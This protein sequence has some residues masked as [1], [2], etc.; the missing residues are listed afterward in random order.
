MDTSFS[1]AVQ[2]MPPPVAVVIRSFQEFASGVPADPDLIVELLK[3][4]RHQYII[5]QEKTGNFVEYKLSDDV[6]LHLTIEAQG[7][8]DSDAEESGG[9]DDEGKD[10]LEEDLT[11]KVMWARFMYTLPVTP[12]EARPVRF[13]CPA[14]TYPATV[15]GFHDFFQKFK[16]IAPDLLRRGPCPASAHATGSLA[17]RVRG[18]EFCAGCCLKATFSAVKR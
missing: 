3:H 16:E 4:I 15:A 14:F 12:H 5:N 6:W 11:N 1:M 9:S 2:S 7:S 13:I 10:N 8:D 17:F 18:A